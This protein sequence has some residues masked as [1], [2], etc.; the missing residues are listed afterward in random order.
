MASW[1]AQKERCRFEPRPGSLYSKGASLNP[2]VL[3]GTGEL[4]AGW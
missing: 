2:G 4:T 1:L 3:M